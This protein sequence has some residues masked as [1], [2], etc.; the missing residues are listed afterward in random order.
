MAFELELDDQILA[1]EVQDNFILAW[2]S[3]ESDTQDITNQLQR[4]SSS[5][6]FSGPFPFL[7]LLFTLPYPSL[8]VLSYLMS[9]HCVTDIGYSQTGNYSNNKLNC[10]NAHCC[11]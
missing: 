1:K 11:S 5:S 8:S 4:F 10:K 6:H 2:D 3:I 7:T 9:F